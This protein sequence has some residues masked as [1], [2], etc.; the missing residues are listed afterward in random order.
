M[1]GQADRGFRIQILAEIA[2]IA[3]TELEPLGQDPFGRL[4][5]LA[6]EAVANVVAG[7]QLIRS[8][9]VKSG[10]SL[11]DGAHKVAEH[12][13]AEDLGLRPAGSEV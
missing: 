5:G 8:H 6:D 12:R 4:P 13:A 11:V 2:E 10:E 9:I 1:V 7:K 3:R